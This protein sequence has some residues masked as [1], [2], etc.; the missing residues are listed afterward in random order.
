MNKFGILL[1]W[2]ILIL[3]YTAARKRL[4]RPT[5]ST[6]SLTSDQ[7]VSA[8]VNRFKVTRNRASIKNTKNELQPSNGGSLNKK[9][10]DY[11]VHW[12]RII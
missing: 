4:R 2:F 3:L 7:E 8:S 1:L 12:F 11:K 10:N 9:S 5:V 6:S